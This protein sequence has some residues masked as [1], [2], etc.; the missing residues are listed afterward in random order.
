MPDESCRCCGGSLTDRKVCKK[1]FQ[2]TSEACTECGN[3]TLEKFHTMNL[4]ENLEKFSKIIPK[5]GCVFVCNPNNPTGELLEKKQVL[6]ITDVAKSKSSILFVDESFIELVPGKSQ[7]VALYAPKKTNLFVLRS[8]TKSFAIPGVRAGYSIANKTMTDLINRTSMPWNVSI[9]AQRAAC[10]AVS[11][12]KIHLEKAHHLIKKES[13][14]L[15]KNI[16]WIQM[17]AKP[18]AN[19]ILGILQLAYTLEKTCKT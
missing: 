11:S 9:L 8:L 14:F 17:C 10:A 19:F 7:S 1:C 6:Y 4:G 16:E 12:H 18:S 13:D 15:Q 3:H 5:N 2:S